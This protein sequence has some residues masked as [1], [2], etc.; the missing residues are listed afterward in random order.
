[1]K[2]EPSWFLFCLGSDEKGLLACDDE[3]DNEMEVDENAPDITEQYEEDGRNIN[4]SKRK[5]ELINEFKL[6]VAF[7]E[8]S[9]ISESNI[10]LGQSV[11]ES[12]EDMIEDGEIPEN[13]DKSNLEHE[14]GNN[15]TVS[16]STFEEHQPTTALMLQFDQVLT[17][18]LLKYH[19]KW[20]ENG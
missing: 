5:F 20:L 14:E 7:V 4:I 2:D 11:D 17:Q 10:A 19:T 3:S 16:Q 15:E 13:I 1:M 12:T 8:S 9:N 6:D 18:K